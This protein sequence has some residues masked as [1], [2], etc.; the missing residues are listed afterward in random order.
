MC[1]LVYVV[2]NL[3]TVAVLLSY[4]PRGATYRPC[5]SII[6]Y[7]VIWYSGAQAIHVVLNHIS[8]PTWQSS[9]AVLVAALLIRAR[10]NVARA[11]RLERYR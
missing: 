2:S 6:A 4:R 5:M 11:V 10:G 3:I 9:I 7:V 8:I 1:T